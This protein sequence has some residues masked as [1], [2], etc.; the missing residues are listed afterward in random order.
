MNTQKIPDVS[1]PY[2]LFTQWFGMAKKAEPNNPNAMCLSTVNENGVPS[3]RMVLL[4]GYDSKGFVFYTNYESQKGQEILSTGKAALCFYWKTLQKQIRISGIVTSVSPEEAD[5]YFS[6]RPR[7]SKI[8]AW[9]S[10]Q[11]SILKGGRT[12]LEESIKK[13]EE[14]FGSGD[15]IPRPPHWSGFRVAPDSIEF[16][17]EMPYRLHDRVF[18]EKSG[19]GWKTRRLYP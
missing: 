4:K 15:D 1:S 9:A 2:T 12:E 11:S 3:S 14:K 18:Y 8:G 10:K 13:Y 6:T 16:W 7:G 5:A 17:Q 19:K